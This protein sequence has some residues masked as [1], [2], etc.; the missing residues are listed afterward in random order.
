MKIF[1]LFAVFCM[2][3]SF[4]VTDISAQ[5]L[6]QEVP[7]NISYLQSIEFT[8]ANS[9]VTTGWGL[10]TLTT[11]RAYYTTN[12][13]TTWIRA[14]VPDSSHMIVS[15]QY[16]TSQILYGTGAVNVYNEGMDF[17]SISNN[18]MLEPRSGD[19][20]RGA[21]F[22]STNG[23]ASWLTYGT[24][25]DDCYHA[26]YSQFINANTGMC[27]ASTE[28]INGAD[29][30]ILKTTNGG[31]TWTKTISYDAIRQY[32][33]INYVNE[34]LA[35]TVGYDFTEPVKRGIIMRTTNGGINWTTQYS[36]STTY[37]GIFFT[38]NNTGFIS[39][40]NATGGH[41]WKTTNQGDTWDA[42]YTK[43]SLIIQG[44]EFHNGGPVGI[45][46]GVKI[47][48]GK[49]FQPFAMRTA[50]NGATWKI[51]VIQDEHNRPTVTSGCMI[52]NFNYYLGG[53]TFSEPRIYHT[54]NGG[55]TSVNNNTGTAAKEF[56]LEQNY[57]NPFNP[58]TSIRY[59]IPVTGLVS[60][61]IYNG[62]GKE[63]VELVN[64]VKPNGQYEVSFDASN[65][66][67]GVYFYKLTT[68]NFSE[69]KKMLLIK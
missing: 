39:G 61:K 11:C 52:D 2:L 55:S 51:Q 50:D 3:Y 58:A 60:I 12:G 44:I 67:S 46:Y 53:G 63:I 20:T 41:I 1:K 32:N 54:I 49:N 31:L 19:Y 40:G 8:N 5:W 66:T 57:P 21:F 10:D 29:M 33:A 17:A 22:K 59:N 9:G 16:I 23:G 28:E 56:S 37:T 6:Q 13:G 4:H 69:T 36:D 18:G 65:L 27:I 45:A 48:T 47:Y 38:S 30:N 42:I 14:S 24:L 64:E 25:P 26:S 15:T 7:G 62:L 34:N 43:D 35:F 68:G